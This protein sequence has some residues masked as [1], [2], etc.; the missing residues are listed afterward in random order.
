MRLG[1]CSRSGDIVEPMLRPQWYVDCE[2]MAAA[3]L[4]VSGSHRLSFRVVRACVCLGDVYVYVEGF[5]NQSG[6]SRRRN[7][8]YSFVLQRRMGAL[9][10]WYSSLVCG[11]QWFGGRSEQF[12][13]D[14]HPI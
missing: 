13:F 1:I 12:V 7:G 8:A 14:G 9:V 2:G 11:G 6:G 10:D 5:S 4:K 3:A